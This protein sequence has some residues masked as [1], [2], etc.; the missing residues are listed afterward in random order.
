M[1]PNDIRFLMIG[2]GLKEVE[3]ASVKGRFDATYLK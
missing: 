3:R 1:D 2:A